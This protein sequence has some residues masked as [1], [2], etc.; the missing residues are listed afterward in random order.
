VV[1][2][3]V[4]VEAVV[5]VVGAVDDVAAVVV[6]VS[7][8]EVV[9]AAVV[10]VVVSWA[11]DGKPARPTNIVSKAKAAMRA[12]RKGLHSAEPSG[13]GWPSWSLVAIPD[14]LPPAKKDPKKDICSCRMES[15]FHRPGPLQ[16]VATRPHRWFD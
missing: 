2:A 13:R 5:V 14:L 1:G 8:D 3:W 4:V 16:P 9:D 6:V 12:K 15:G 11:L 7:D 10:E